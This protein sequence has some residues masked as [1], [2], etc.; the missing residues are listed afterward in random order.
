M[1]SIRLA[2]I[3]KRFKDVI[4]FEN[5]D[6]TIHDGEFFTFLG[7]S[8][9]G[10]ST[11]LNLIAGLEEVSGGKIYFDNQD[12]T[13]LP[14]ARRDVAMVFQSYALYPHMSVFENIAFPLKIKKM[15]KTLIKKEVER[16]ASVLGLQRL[17]DRKPRELSGG[18]R[19][20]VALGRAMVREPRVFLM[21]EPLSNLDA[22]LRIEMR[23]EL[24]RLHQKLGTT[25]VYVTHD[26]A[27]AMALSERIAIL[28]NGIVQQCAD[29]LSIYSRPANTFVASF[30][31]T[32]PM[33]IIETVV[34]EK[35]PPVLSLGKKRYK[36]A[37]ADTLNFERVLLG[38]RPEDIEIKPFSREGIEGIVEIVEPEGARF[39]IDL[40][41]DGIL[42]KAISDKRFNPGDKVYMEIPDE[43]I[44]LFTRDTGER[45]EITYR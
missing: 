38:V 14:P 39:L 9:C 32:P 35:S 36:L 41:F 22:R 11:L 30:I 43:K 3:T 44:H 33:N 37:R 10:K 1:S 40:V 45:I 34:I 13:H 12:V 26:Q 21:D 24:K 17:L 18:Q 23:S 16:V 6:L 8:G 20:R 31:G 5:I 27:E 28:N 25:I 29:P 7:P 4:V 42:L 15:D 19:Q 2:N